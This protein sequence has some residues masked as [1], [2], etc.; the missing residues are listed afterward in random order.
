MTQKN[1]PDREDRFSWKQ[2]ELETH[3]SQCANCKNNRAGKRC[4]V[5]ENI[6]DQ[7]LLNQTACPSRE[8]EDE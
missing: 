6:P 5:Y 2:G 8:P 1:N 4:L 7:Y 3:T